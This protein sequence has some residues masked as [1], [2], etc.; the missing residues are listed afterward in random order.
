MCRNKSV[1]EELFIASTKDIK[2]LKPG[3]PENCRSIDLQTFESVINE[4]MQ[5]AYHHG[6]LS[7]S[8]NY[9]Y[10]LEAHI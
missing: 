8:P 6:R 1:I 5:E 4:K 9:E 2:S 10:P 3:D 7:A